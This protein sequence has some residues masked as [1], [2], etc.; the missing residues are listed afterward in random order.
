MAKALPWSRTSLPR[1]DLASG[2]L[3]QPVPLS[4]KQPEKWYLAAKNGKFRE[5]AASRFRDWLLEETLLQDG[6][7]QSLAASATRR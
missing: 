1:P 5:P 4:V 6:S 7:T 2:R 3:V